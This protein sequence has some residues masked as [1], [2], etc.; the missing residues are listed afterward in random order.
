MAAGVAAAAV[1]AAIILA[2][3]RGDV[4]R[5]TYGD[6][7]IYRYVAAHFAQD[8]NDVSPVVRERGTSL[9]YGRVGLPALI[10]VASAGR[11]SAMPY[12]QPA[13]IVLAAAAAG[14]ATARLLP[15]AGPIAPMIPFLAPG[16]S[17]AVSGGFA[18]V[19]AVAFALWAV[20]AARD[21]RWGVASVLLAAALL[22]RENAGAVLL[23]LAVWCVLRRRLSAVAVLASSA[24]PVLV[25]YAIV[26]ARY[27]HFPILDPYL[28][29]TTDTIGPPV[30][31]IARALVDSPA[32]SVATAAI[33]LALAIIAFALWRRSI[34]GAVAAAAGIQVLAA[35][36]FSF[37]F[38]GEAFRQF[39][40]LQ[41][42]L[43]AALMWSRWSET[44]E[45][46]SG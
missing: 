8:P 9:R 7:L 2:N 14:I 15:R 11:P 16:F 41:L 1:A 44:A 32:S 33:H 39:V 38:E 35:G 34:A 45:G 22:T 17:L 10:W 43:I 23:G 21:E 19:V 29:V 13:I 26:A 4:D 12:A 3:S 20:V 40:F 42:F 5:M 18:E 27:G 31:A 46:T 36:R 37:A 6:G 30:G 25:W 24:G 28:R